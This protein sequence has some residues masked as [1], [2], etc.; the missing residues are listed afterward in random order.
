MVGTPTRTA[1]YVF[2]RNEGGPDN[3]GQVIKRGGIVYV[4]LDA[5]SDPDVAS[6]VGNAMFA[7]L[8][9]VAGSLYKESQTGAP[10]PNIAVHADEFNELVGREFVPLANK[11]GGAGFQRRSDAFLPPCGPGSVGFSGPGRS[12]DQVE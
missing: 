8:T 4:G 12:D 7:D 10:M 6:A 11:A 9:S 2:E 3:W 1:A 5:L